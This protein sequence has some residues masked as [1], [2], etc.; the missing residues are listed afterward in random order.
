MIFVND[1]R[2]FVLY[3]CATCVKEGLRAVY[4]A[5]F[6]ILIKLNLCIRKL[7]AYVLR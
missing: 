5:S 7:T 1:D 3:W 4:I 6:E 2:E